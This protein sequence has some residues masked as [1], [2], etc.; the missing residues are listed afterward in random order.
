MRL[1]GHPL[2][3]HGES[4]L[5]T[6]CRWLAVP[7]FAG[8]YGCRASGAGHLPAAGPAIVVVDHKSNVDPV[9]IGMIFDRPLRYM[10]K[11]ELF[12]L[13]P[14]EWLITTLGAFPIERGAGDTDRGQYDVACDIFALTGALALGDAAAACSARGPPF[15]AAAGAA[16]FAAGG[17]GFGVAGAWAFSMARA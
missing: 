5:Y 8:L 11:K 9:M 13:R 12:A 16:P 1:W 3:G 14:L 2:K 7:L 6:F 17:A 4:R 10:A 15:S